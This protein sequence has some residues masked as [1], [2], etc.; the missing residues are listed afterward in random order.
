MES[1]AKGEMICWNKV[2]K[3]DFVTKT[4]V[5]TLTFGK[6]FNGKIRNKG[7]QIKEMICLRV[8]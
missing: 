6:L 5:A 2:C 3:E 7:D 1:P 8:I 4:R